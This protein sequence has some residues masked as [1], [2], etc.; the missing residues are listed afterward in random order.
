MRSALGQA[1][2]DGAEQKGEKGSGRG[3]KGC[4]GRIDRGFALWENSDLEEM[5]PWF[6]RCIA[7]DCAEVTVL[8][9][10]GP[11]ATRSFDRGEL[12]HRVTHDWARKNNDR[13]EQAQNVQA[14]TGATARTCQPRSG[15]RSRQ[16][17]L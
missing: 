15:R 10:Y 1:E 12:P 13:K 14:K 16:A 2:L 3:Q 11:T 17:V 8:R 7:G 5:A 6:D 4:W 9:S